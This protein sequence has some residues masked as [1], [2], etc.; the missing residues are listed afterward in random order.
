MG[1]SNPAAT[2]RC[3]LTWEEYSHSLELGSPGCG[4][5]AGTTSQVYVNVA[6]V[7]TGSTPADASSYLTPCA[8]MLNGN[9]ALFLNT[10]LIVS[11]TSARITGP[12]TPRCS[13]AA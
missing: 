2:S 3:S 13:Q 6:P 4:P 5:A 9:R 1:P 11:P 10:T 7:W 8:W 12:S